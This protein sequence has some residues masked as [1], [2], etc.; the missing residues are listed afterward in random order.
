[1]KLYFE[2]GIIRNPRDGDVVAVLGLGFPVFLG[3]PFRY[4][5]SLGLGIIL[6]KLEALSHRFGSRFA[7]SR[8]LRELVLKRKRFYDA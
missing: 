5:D 7:P 3:G 6:E 2:E 4:A 8:L 1:M